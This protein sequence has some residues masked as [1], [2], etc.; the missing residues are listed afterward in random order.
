[1]IS[2]RGGLIRGSPLYSDPGQGYWI[3]QYRHDLVLPRY[4]LLLVLIFATAGAIYCDPGLRTGGFNG[5]RIV[6]GAVIAIKTHYHRVVPWT[7]VDK[8]REDMDEKVRNSL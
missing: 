3:A 2:P 6:S 7:D 1:M 8:P 4:V 5:E